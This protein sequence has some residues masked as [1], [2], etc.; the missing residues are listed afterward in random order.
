MT[1]LAECAKRLNNDN[2]K[3]V[4]ASA[5]YAE[6]FRTPNI[7]ERIKSTTSGSFALLDQES[8]EVEFGIRLNDT[9]FNISASI[10]SMD[11]RNEIQ[12]DQSKNTNLDPISREGLNLDFDYEINSST[13]LLGSYSYAQAEFTSGTLSPGGGGT[14]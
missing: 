2:T 5:K 9:K 11:T 10:Y 7:D 6:S 1:G 4:K 12:Y 13:M 8:D 3:N 14:G